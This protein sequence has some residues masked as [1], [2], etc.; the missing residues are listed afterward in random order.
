MIAEINSF[1]VAPASNNSYKSDSDSMAFKIS[2][3]DI[4][5]TKKSLTT[6][7]INDY[8]HNAEKAMKKRASNQNIRYLKL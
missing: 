8:H 1:N 3:G 5:S 4:S 6:A 7:Q 2:N